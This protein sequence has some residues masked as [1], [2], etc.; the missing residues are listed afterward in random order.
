MFLNKSTQR[1]H[2]PSQG[3]VFL[4]QT[5]EI[6]KLFIY[7]DGGWARLT[8]PCPRVLAP[9]PP[10]AHAERVALAMLALAAERVA[11]AML[12]LAVERVGLTMLASELASLLMPR[13]SS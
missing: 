8:C 3:T 13:L 7:I 9:L 5:F 10:R 6:Y 1:K 12:A 4:V 11:L 2:A